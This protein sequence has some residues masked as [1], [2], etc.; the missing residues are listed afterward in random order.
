MCFRGD[1]LVECGR[2]TIFITLQNYHPIEQKVAVQVLLWD[3]NE[4][5]ITGFI[6]NSSAL[7]IFHLQSEGFKI[8]VAQ[9]RLWS[10]K[11]RTIVSADFM[12]ALHP[13][14][15]HTR[16]GS[17]VMG[18]MCP[19]W[20]IPTNFRNTESCKHKKKIIIVLY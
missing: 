19:P 4:A 3:Q 8:K 2:T 13:L 9:E 15:M 16:K 17:F 11:I 5:D 10:L 20:C 6:N 18:L 12:V 7:Q 1:E 14:N